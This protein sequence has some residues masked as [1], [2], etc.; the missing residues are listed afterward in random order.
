MPKH[1]FQSSTPK[2]FP[3]G[4]LVR[5]R[6]V[7]GTEL[8]G[9]VIKIETTGLGTFLHIEYDDG[10]INVTRRQIIGYYD[11]SSVS[12]LLAKYYR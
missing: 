4:L 3:I 9:I 11:F 5:V 7:A 6:M 8:E 2:K 12:G 1:S 10:V